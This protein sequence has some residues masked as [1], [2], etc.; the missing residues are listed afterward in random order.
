MLRQISIWLLSCKTDTKIWG[1][2]ADQ[3]INHRKPQLSHFMCHYSAWNIRYK[4][5]P[6]VLI[7][8]L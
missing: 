3:Y 4:A 7:M 1:Y 5:F 8:A 6:V 2:T